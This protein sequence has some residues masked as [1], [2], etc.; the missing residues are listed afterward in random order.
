MTDKDFD[1]RLQALEKA[2]EGFRETIRGQQNDINELGGLVTRAVIRHNA[3]V[4][5]LADDGALKTKIITLH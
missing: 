2:V 1:R 4:D 3:L 5:R